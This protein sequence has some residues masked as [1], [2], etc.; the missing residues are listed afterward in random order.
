MAEAE[1]TLRAIRRG[2]VDALVVSTPQGD[3]IFTLKGA[4][5][6]YRVLMENMKEGAIT[7]AG[8]DTIFYCNKGF[9]DMLKKPLKKIIGT[10]IS[11]FVS[12][13][14]RS[15]FEE[16]L[17]QGRA[18]SSKGETIFI[19]GDGTA[20]PVHLSVNAMPLD[21]LS[22]VYLV[23][24]DLTE[25][26]RI[27]DEL[28]EARDGLEIRVEERT[29]ELVKS[30]QRWAT[31]LAS[32][33]DAV[34]ATDAK[35]RI[36]FMN[37]VSEA[38]TGWKLADAS[39][40][41][42]TEV[43]NIINEYT[44]QKVDNPV[45][46]VLREGMIIGLA[47]HTIL[48]R[49][50]GTELPIDDSGAP[51]KDVDGKTMGVVLVFRDITERRRAEE[52]RRESEEKYRNIVETAT[53]GIWIVDTQRKTTYANPK[54]AELL[55]YSV[56]E[57]MGKSGLDF[58]DEEGVA[59]SN[60]NIEKRKQGIKGSYEL[61]LIRRDGSPLWTIVNAKPLFDMKGRFTGTLSMLT[62]I[63]KRKRAEEALRKAHDELELRVRE[64]T[65][66][67]EEANKALLESA[68]SYRELTESIDDLFY[69]MD[70]DLRY[71]YWNKASEVLTGIPANDAIGKSL[72]E[73]FPD[74]KGTKAER[75]YIRILKTQQPEHFESQFQIDDKSLVFEINAYPT[76]TG[77][78]VIAKD[79]T[80]KKYLEAQ[81]LRAQRMESIGTLAS[82]M[83]HD[84]NNVLT[85]IM[86]SLHILKEKFKDEQSQKLLTVLEQ[87]S[88]RGAN[89]IKQ[90][91][92]FARGVEGEHKPLQI[93]HLISEIEKVAKETFPRNIKIRTDISKD[94]FTISGDV[95]QLHQ[96][97]MNLCVNAR[98]AMPD[99]GILDITALNFFID[100]NYTRMHTEAKIGSYVIIEVSDTG[101]GIPGDIIDR[102]FEPF[103]TTKKFGEGTGLG[104][105]TAIAIVKSHGGFINVYSETGKGTIFRVYLPSVKTELQKVDDKQLELLAGQGELVM[106]AEDEDSIREVTASILEEYGYNVLAANDGAQAV[107]LYAQNKDKIKVVIMDMMMPVMDGHMSIRAIRRINP[108]VKIVAVSGLAEKDRLKDVIENTDAFLP[109]PYTAGRLL[110]TI[111]EVL[112]S[113]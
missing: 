58:L 13:A 46:R 56:H 28:R 6:P 23:A 27:Q 104:L 52:A 47:N 51:I 111:H 67:L 78:S 43:F 99:G 12:P 90:V 39:T 82:G 86:L 72:Y 84:L 91:L 94:L 57:M 35:G 40:K 74:I 109:K 4:E 96:V 83:A 102:I 76:R 1:E 45:A 75:F 89:L 60:L 21:G 16:L 113:K 19:A 49:K 106:V 15:V 87:N 66:E 9:A 112:D 105:S 34:I 55:G 2:E 48:I 63:T 71:T 79:V 64:R 22:S 100:E 68:A 98:D 17:R 62:D 97:L 93:A 69:A 30:E 110:E 10:G 53:E 5:R 44:R 88:Q 25:Q 20:V 32:I 42:M 95:T 37:A 18:G 14:D 33:G 41:P 54:M 77:I 61:K 73:L 101:T 7:L 108:Q 80:N 36:T 107:A 50:D 85:P 29:A 31:T 103:F 38:L 3:Q 70:E 81:L 92:S 26:K 59:L 8:D 24:T 11:Q 65:S